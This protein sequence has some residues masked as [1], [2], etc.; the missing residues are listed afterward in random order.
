MNAQI[1][2]FLRV[3][4]GFFPSLEEIGKPI[5]LFLCQKN[6]L[7]IFIFL[8]A[9][10]HHGNFE[11]EGVIVHQRRRSTSLVFVDI[12]LTTQLKE[13]SPEFLQKYTTVAAH[14]RVSANLYLESQSWRSS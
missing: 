6:S 11:A 14:C 10:F 8:S 7:F 3:V 12:R 5:F 4:S 1:S 9:I 13:C 2:M